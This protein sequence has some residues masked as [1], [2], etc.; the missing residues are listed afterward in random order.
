MNGVLVDS[1]VLLDLFTSDP[2]WADWS[3][4]ILDKYSQTNS[5]YINS[6]V[7]TEVS[8]GFNLKNSVA[9]YCGSLKHSILRIFWNIWASPVG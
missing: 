8:I 3:E 6:M 9:I 2:N 1:Y 5:L 4:N 7:Y